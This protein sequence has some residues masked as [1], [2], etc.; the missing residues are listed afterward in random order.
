[1]NACLVMHWFYNGLPAST[2]SSVSAEATVA[3][4]LI[5]Q[6]LPQW[7]ASRVWLGRVLMLDALP[8]AT[9]KGICVSYRDAVCCMGLHT[10]PKVKSVYFLNFNKKSLEG[11]VNF[12]FWISC[13]YAE[14]YLFIY[15]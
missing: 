12:T 10:F 5:H 8:D 3:S 7:V 11:V 4:S 13:N 6:G 9:P 14:N 15:I 1:M 2:V